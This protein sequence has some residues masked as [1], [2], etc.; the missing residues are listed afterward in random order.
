MAQALMQPAQSAI[1]SVA[2]P[3]AYADSTEHRE[4]IA[5]FLQKRSPAF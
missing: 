1:D 4:G 2:D 5:A 3:Y